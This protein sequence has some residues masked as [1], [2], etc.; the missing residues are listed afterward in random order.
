V[1]DRV[2]RAFQADASRMSLLASTR[3]AS[4]V[5][6]DDY[7]A[8]YYTGGH[9]TMWDFPDEPSFQ[10]AA[11]RIYERGGWV[12]AVCHGVAGL[13]NIKLA[14]GDYL[15]QRKR[16]TGYSDREESFGGTS[17][18]VPYSL[19]SELRAR[20]ADYVRSSVPFVPHAIVDGRLITGQNPF[21][22]RALARL[23]RQS[24]IGGVMSQVSRDF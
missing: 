20:G 6:G 8:I 21:S 5:R 12:A 9:G 22:T 10:A 2:I 15:I 17:R 16:L 1:T 4:E 3:K 23:L 14:N 24:L 19:E 18:I 7:D 13:L 11:R